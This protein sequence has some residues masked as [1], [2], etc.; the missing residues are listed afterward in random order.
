MGI[1][2]CVMKKKIAAPCKSHGGGFRRAVL[3]APAWEAKAT[4]GALPYMAYTG[5]A[6]GQ[7]MIS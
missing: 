5:C 6:E 7:G 4:M 2:C 1:K 3:S